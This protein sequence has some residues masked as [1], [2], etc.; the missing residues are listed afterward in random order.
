MWA[1]RSPGG[2][3]GTRPSGGQMEN[4]VDSVHESGEMNTRS[5]R[6]DRHGGHSCIV[7]VGVTL[8]NGNCPALT[9]I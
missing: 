4:T 1:R 9:K 2:L 8:I 6:Q 7:D 3:R 5:V